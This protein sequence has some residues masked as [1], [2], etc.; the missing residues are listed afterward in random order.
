MTISIT[1]VQDV[2]KIDYDEL[3]SSSTIKL[4]NKTYSVTVHDS[5]DVSVNRKFNLF[6]QLLR[7]LIALYDHYERL[8]NP[9]ECNHLTRSE[10][11]ADLIQLSNPK[12]IE[13]ITKSYDVEYQ[14]GANRAVFI[15]STG[16]GYKM[17]L[18]KHPM[19]A[20]GMAKFEQRLNQIYK[21]PD[22]YGG[23]YAHLATTKT[24][25]IKTLVGTPIKITSFDMIK[26]AEKL[27][28]EINETG[29]VA[30]KDCEKVPESA[31]EE[32]RKAGFNPW[33]VKPDNFVKIKND[34]G[35]YDYL[36]IDAKLI[37]RTK[38]GREA[39]TEWRDRRA[40]FRTRKIEGLQ[41]TT[42]DKYDFKEQFVDKRA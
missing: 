17:P 31:L 33:D 9:D 23:K 13:H 10:Q 36:P 28:Y 24:T 34:E 11:M 18:D 29:G 1:S 30:Y 6:L 3:K 42:G 25:T 5:G 35:G 41:L 12:K 19:I 7:P 14:R 39:Q 2:R 4:N 26:G 20:K 22:F 21:S 38:E 40:S 27:K 8:N 15:D 16:H 37:G 32:L